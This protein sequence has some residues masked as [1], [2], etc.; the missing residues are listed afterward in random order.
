LAIEQINPETGEVEIRAIQT[1]SRINPPKSHHKAISLLPGGDKYTA[2]TKWRRRIFGAFAIVVLAWFCYNMAINM[3]VGGLVQAPEGPTESQVQTAFKKATAPGYDKMKYLSDTTSGT[4]TVENVE[5][6][7]V[8]T[9]TGEVSVG[10]SCEATAD[11]KFSNASLNSTSKMRV[12]FSYNSLLHTWEAGEIST[13]RSNYRP[14]SGP[15]LGKVQSDAINLLN[16]YDSDA[17]TKMK[18]A[19]I[20]REGSISKDGG[21]VTIIFTKEGAGTT[22]YN[23]YYGY[24]TTTDLVKTMDVRVEW[25]EISGWVASVTWLRTEGEGLEDTTSTDESNST[26]STSNETATKELSCSSGSYVRLSGTVSGTTLT[27]TESTKY[28]IDGEEITT[29]EITLTGNTSNITN[30]SSDTI[31]GYISVEDGKVT[32]QIP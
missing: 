14:N 5:V 11:V 8:V 20:T 19:T 3:N 4:P 17:A 13:E 25:S 6:G 1:N 18:D 26:S 23:Y 12:K 32:L 10:Y 15:D 31:S 2:L 24:S 9:N 27:T 22:T 28:T 29:K 30:Q 21:T 16:S 7:K